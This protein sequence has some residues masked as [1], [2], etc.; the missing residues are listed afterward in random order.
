MKKDENR[1]LKNVIELGI[2]PIPNKDF[3]SS[4]IDKIR[5]LETEKTTLN[6]SINSLILT[7]IF[8][9]IL[10]FELFSVLKVLAVIIP[11]NL[12]TRIL[13]ITDQISNIILTPTILTITLSFL[14]LYYFDVY[15]KKK[16]S[17]KYSKPNKE[18]S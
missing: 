7:P 3:T 1:M 13:Q 14:I 2:K 15:L 8:I 18:L 5:A 10:L 9:F 12:D 16:I 11:R 17:G 4:T 6:Y